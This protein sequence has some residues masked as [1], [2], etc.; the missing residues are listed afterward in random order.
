MI[1]ETLPTDAQDGYI[2]RKKFKFG[3][4]L[5]AGAVLVVSVFLVPRFLQ[6]YSEIIKAE[7]KTDLNELKTAIALFAADQKTLPANVTDG[8]CVVGETYPNGTCLGELLSSGHLPRLPESPDKEPYYYYTVDGYA[9][10]ATRLN[11]P[12]DGED[13]A[14]GKCAHG[15]SEKIWC[16]GYRHR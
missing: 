4:L 10:V 11:P 13:I 7:K 6:M 5:V 16:L 9:I 3:K 8:W 14:I 2:A 1:S 12:E 15:D